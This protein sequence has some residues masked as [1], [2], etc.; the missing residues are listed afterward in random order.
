MQPLTARRKREL[1][2]KLASLRGELESWEQ[3]TEVPPM[4]RHRSQV[5][6]LK[7]TVLAL[8]DAMAASDA[9]KQSAEEVILA[10]AAS[11]E[12]RLLTAHAIWEVFRSKLLQRSDDRFRQRLIAYDDLAWVCYEPAMTRY[13]TV[14]REPP[15]VYLNSTWSAF[16]IRRDAA[17]G[18]EVHEGRDTM[19]ALREADYQTTLKTLPIPLLA[20]P[21]FQIE[22]PPSALMIAHEVGHAVEFDFALTDRIRDA[23]RDAALDFES[24]WLACASEV[25]ADLYGCL[26]LGRHFADTLLDLLVAD[27]AAVESEDAFGT[28]PTRA[29]RVQLMVKAL[30]FLGR[31]GEAT[32][33]RETWEAVYGPPAALADHDEDADRVVAA[34]Y[35]EPV[36]NGARRLGLATLITPPTANIPAIAQYASQGNKTEL[37]KTTDAR[38][39]F[40]ALREVYESSP[41]QVFSKASDLLLAQVVQRHDLA[42]RSRSGTV[43]TRGDLDARTDALADDDRAA[44][45][46]IETLLGL[47]DP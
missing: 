23:L 9:W 30:T 3:R 15:L 43:S 17:F 21:W 16:L 6:R 46:A 26:C 37:A 10:K 42:F 18:R 44:A 11:W 13:S 7:C 47:E 22:H 5:R 19:L 29:F 4:R 36:Q 25:F 8:L 40:C 12:K 45:R 24:E 27:K 38:A 32:A 20:L 14:A 39:L 35:G 31:S 34:I 1:D 41:P 28:Y 2:V 33:V